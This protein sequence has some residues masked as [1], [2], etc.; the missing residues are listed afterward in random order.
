MSVELTMLLYSVILMFV[1]IAIPA[2]VAILANGLTTQAGA[3][4]SLPEPSVFYKRAD[5]LRANMIENM[6]LFA[7]LVLIANAMD[8]STGTTVLGAQLF[9]FARL[10]H[11]VIYLAGWPLVRPLV[12]FVGLAGCIMI[13]VAI[14]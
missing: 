9:F 11:A 6:M 4:D 8:I 1:F 10:L 13:A 5:R 2:T 14:L 3:R 12:Y 7:P